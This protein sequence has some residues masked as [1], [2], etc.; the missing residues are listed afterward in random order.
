MRGPAV[1]YHILYGGSHG[2]LPC[3][4][5]ALNWSP[6]P[7]QARADELVINATN[8]SAVTVDAA[9]AR[10]S[11]RARLDITSDGPLRVTMADRP[12]GAG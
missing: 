11:C 9:R 6:A 1:G 12:R 8:V 3:Q 10:V 4:E 2:P 7:R 5:R